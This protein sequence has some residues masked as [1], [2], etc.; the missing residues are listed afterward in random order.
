MST[1][2]VK[3]EQPAAS[4]ELAERLRTVCVGA[5]KDLEVVRHLFHGEPS[6]VVRDPL[7]FESFRF[8][9]K[10]YVIFSA[11]TREKSLDSIFRE[12]V[13]KG[14]LGFANESAFYETVLMLHRL[15]FL[16]L[17]VSDDKRLFERH[18]AR[19]KARTKEKIFGIL[20][21]RIPVFNPDALLNR[22][23]K[24][25]AVLFSPMFFFLWLLM[26][27]GA[28]TIAVR[29][30]DELFMPVQ[31]ILAAKNLPFI[32]ILLIALK[33]LHEFGHACACKH[34]GGHVPEMGIFMV[35]FAP[36]AYVD[37]TAS[38][39]FSSKRERI[40]VGLGG[41]YFESI[42]AALA[43]FTWALTAPGLLHDMAYNVIFLA[44]VATVFFNINPL[45]RYDG[46]YILSDLLEVPNL[47]S[48]AVTY[49][50]SLLKRIFLGFKSRPQNLGFRMK[51]FLFLFGIAVSLYKLVLV[52]VISVAIATKLLVVG[53]VLAC[54]YI[55]STFVS[56]FIKLSRYLFF[57]EETAPI[58]LRAATIGLLLFL[59]LPV[60]LLYLPIPGTIHANGVFERSDK[61]MIYAGSDGFIDRVHVEDGETV[62][63]G[64]LLY[65][66]S[67]DAYDEATAV[68]HARFESAQLR[69]QAWQ[70]TDLLKALQE[71]ERVKHFALELRQRK[72]EQ[73]ALKVTANFSGEAIQCLDD[74]NEGRFI[75]K[76]EPLCTLV[77]GTWQVRALMTEKEFMDI[78]PNLGD[79]VRVLSPARPGQFLNGEILR[80]IPKGDKRIDSKSFTQEGGGSI[81]VDPA[82]H[83]AVEPYFEI[84]IK[85]DD[86]HK[87]WIRYGMTC[88]VKC[89][90][91]T[92]T[93]GN[94]VSRRIKLFLT[95]LMQ[96]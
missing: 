14:R 3:N 45:M 66:M 15:N 25:A 36:L 4:S 22:M 75:R 93:V 80:V 63:S 5:R 44:G 21:L 58:R 92:E 65:S 30:A 7:T 23:R 86:A 87:E 18:L 26:M 29:G 34:F 32:F 59:V 24:G 79:T 90:R 16:N 82:T 37:A 40:I 85:L 42:I 91:G 78:R 73:A 50:Q 84:T 68:A 11:L 46:Y 47:R 56:L 89:H 48:R 35:V 74:R 70:A 17:P 28:I 27:A 69:N 6:Y 72:D 67:N 19:M 94:L 77:A 13:D 55:G 95:K 52:T 20:F 39:G 62:K 64:D 41:M 96:G 54:A 2:H 33:V 83:E 12:L 1:N 57:S 60:G 38:W 51:V 61:N 43:L 81:A 31:G 53:I 76:G 49:V 10:G 71:E 9:L 8:D 88:R